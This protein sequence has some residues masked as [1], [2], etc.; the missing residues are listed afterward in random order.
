M[1]DSKFSVNYLPKTVNVIV[2]LHELI[3]CLGLQCVFFIKFHLISR[4]NFLIQSTPVISTTLEDKKSVL[5]TGRCLYWV[6]NL[7]VF[8]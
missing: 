8:L 5:V 6:I 7:K 4:G 3:F 1:K 2:L